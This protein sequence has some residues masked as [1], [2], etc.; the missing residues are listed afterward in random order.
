MGAHM[1][2]CRSGSHDWLCHEVVCGA[3]RVRTCPKHR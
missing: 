2:E 1:H 3:A